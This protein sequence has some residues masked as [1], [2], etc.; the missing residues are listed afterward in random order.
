[1]T[2]N[3]YSHACTGRGPTTQR[4]DHALALPNGQS[5][6]IGSTG[7]SHSLVVK[8]LGATEAA[9]VPSVI[10]SSHQVNGGMPHQAVD[11]EVVVKGYRVHVKSFGRSH[12]VHIA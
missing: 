4:I 5:L 2:L 12:C 7:R 9:G 10:L 11:R 3:L 1:M 8:I 6:K